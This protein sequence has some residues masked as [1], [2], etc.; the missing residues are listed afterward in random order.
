AYNKNNTLR[1]SVV[2]CSCCCGDFVG[3]CLPSEKSGFW[4]GCIHRY[5]PPPPT[6]WRIFFLK[7]V[8]YFFIFSCIIKAN[9]K[10]KKRS[11]EHT[12]ELQSRFDL[13][14]CLL[15]EQKK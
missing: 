5:T 2:C 4:G 14:C 8:V 11:E 3:V 15:L 12:S 9:A 13:V 6:A 1:R 10:I 7:L